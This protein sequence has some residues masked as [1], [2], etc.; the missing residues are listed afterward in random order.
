MKATIDIPEPM[1]KWAKIL[2]I[3]RGQSLKQLVLTFG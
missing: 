1:L 3:E 2:A